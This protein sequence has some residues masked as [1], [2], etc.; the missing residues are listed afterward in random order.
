MNGH[1]HLSRG[2]LFY[3]VGGMASYE[4]LGL[5]RGLPPLHPLYPKRRMGS[6]SAFRP[7]LL[8]T[9]SRAV[10][11][12]GSKTPVVASYDTPP[13]LPLFGAHADEV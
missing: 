3:R 6:D 1:T 5:L 10:P 13:A 4:V 12:P 2:C 7:L 9:T 11:L 8:I